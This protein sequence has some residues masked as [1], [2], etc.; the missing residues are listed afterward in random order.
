M[1][2]FKF[3][4]EFIKKLSKDHVAE[5]TAQCAYFSFL[6]FIPF[7]ILLL[8]LIKYI[9]IDKATLEYLLEALLPAITKNSILDIIQEVN[10]KSIQ[11]VSISAIFTLW[12]A[13]NSFYA[14]TLGLSRIYIG[15]ETENS[16]ISL[17]FRGILGTIIVLIS[18]IAVLVLLV[19]G[20]RFNIIIQK[21]YPMFSNIYNLII[22]IRS[23]VVVVFL[24]LVF[25]IIYK[26]APTKRGNKLKNQ[27]PGAIFAS[28][29]LVCCF[30]LFFNIC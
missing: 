14:L 9:D 5:Y 23:I 30:L 2:V 27:I 16:S 18:I 29:R 12:S 4:K 11:T 24:F 15:K 6:S 26:F 13:A 1:K 22:N 28:I 17:R 19:F 25:T 8:S 10:S 20:N 7:I 3:I 21:S